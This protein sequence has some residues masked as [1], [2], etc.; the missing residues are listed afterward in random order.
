MIWTEE[1]TEELKLLWDGGMSANQIAKKFGVTRNSIIGKVHRLGLEGRLG[2]TQADRP[3]RK[4]PS[5]LMPTGRPVVVST[6]NE[7]S[8]PRRFSWQMEEANA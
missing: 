2:P 4:P 3:L 8:P 6:R 5:I 1:R 7:P